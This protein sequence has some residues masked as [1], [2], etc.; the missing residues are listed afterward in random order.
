MPQVRV[1]IA[2]K[3][4]SAAIRREK[5]NGRDVIIVPSATLPDDIVMNG[6]R[7]PAAEIEKSFH[8][9][10]GT[11]AP[12]GHPTVNGKFVS[13]LDP[14]GLA[15]FYVGAHNE[16]VRRENGRVFI[17]KVIDVE[18]ATALAPDLINAIDAGDPI[19]T[20]T[21]LLCNLGDG[22]DEAK[23]TAINM[24]FDHDAILLNEHGAATPDQGVG[25]LVN[26]AVHGG[27]EV[28][29]INSQIED[30]I[31]Y[32]GTE[33]MRAIDRKEAASKWKQIKSAIME[34]I[35]LERE[36]QTNSNE[37]EMTEVT[38]AQFDELSAQVNKLAENMVK[39]DAVKEILDAVNALSQAAEADKK[40]KRDALVNTAVE[41]GILDKAEAEAT[42]DAVLNKLIAADAPAAPLAKGFEVNGKPATFELPE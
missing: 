23:H 41:M 40:A 31:D 24:L 6:I 13:A 4:N 35:G 30:E 15:G 1:N 39:P 27:V 12:L 20:S 11:L 9:L 33:L 29:V 26:S 3:V 2:S 16:N 5:R 10:E 25:M 42:P 38:K 14:D 7:Y 18:K 17:D 34:A 22:D 36:T 32:L 28:E 37:V 8:T 19:H 21:G